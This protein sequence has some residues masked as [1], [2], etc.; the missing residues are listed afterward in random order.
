MTLKVLTEKDKQ[1]IRQALKTWCVAA[2]VTAK[3]DHAFKEI[4]AC[5][6]FYG[7]AMRGEGAC[8]D[9]GQQ[10]PCGCLNLCTKSGD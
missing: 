9:C 4:L 10:L 2:K 5:T 6:P 3:R 7:L 8:L 1:E